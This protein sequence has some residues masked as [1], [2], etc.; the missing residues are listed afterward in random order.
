MYEIFAQ[1]IND[2]T[3]MHW[4]SR[5]RREAGHPLFRGLE[6]DFSDLTY[7][8]T[9]G[10]MRTVLRD[11]GVEPNPAWSNTTTFHLEVKGTMGPCAEP[12]FVPQNQVDKVR[13]RLP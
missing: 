10:R 3:F 6:R 1:Q 7:T 5:L 13:S 2:W 9:T 11:A 4:T 12:M 8:D